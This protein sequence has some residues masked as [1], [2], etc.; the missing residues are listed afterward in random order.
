MYRYYVYNKTKKSWH[1]IELDE[2]VEVGDVIQ[3]NY[4]TEES[5]ILCDCEIIRRMS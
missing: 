2:D 1:F 3:V 4:G 5:F